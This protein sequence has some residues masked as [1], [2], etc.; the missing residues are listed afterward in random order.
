MPGMKVALPAL[1]VVMLMGGTALAQYAPSG[2]PQTMP[3]TQQPPAAP[4][5]GGA[6]TPSTPDAACVAMRQQV[7]TALASKA[8]SPHVKAAK[9]Q[10]ALGNHACAK[11][12]AQTAQT[13]YQK[14]LD[15]LTST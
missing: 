5:T 15:L 13:Y 14:A 4:Q 1:A 12:N 8:S 7:M 10:I 2:Q 11:G 9:H 3:S 6:M